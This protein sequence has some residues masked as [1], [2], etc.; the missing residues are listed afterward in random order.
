[1]NIKFKPSVVQVKF[2]NPRHSKQNVNVL[3]G[4]L[5]ITVS[6]FSYTNEAMHLHT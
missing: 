4:G 3:N 1:M 2:L 5:A 6:I